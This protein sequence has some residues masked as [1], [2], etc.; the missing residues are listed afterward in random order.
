MPTSPEPGA[1]ARGVRF[2]I[3]AKI[4]LWF[5]FNLAFLGA[6]AWIFARVQLRFGLD[7]LLAGPVSDRLQIMGEV[8]TRQ[9]EARPPAEWPAIL[10]STGR[11]YHVQLALYRNDG[12]ALAGIIPEP[13][14][15]VLQRI[16][17]ARPRDGQHPEPM[18]DGPP[19]EDRKS[20]V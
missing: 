15:E 4:L 20:V 10:D 2:P 14:P 6:A 1:A 7:S 9:L 17:D 19:P 8:L 13:P 3:S 12:K 5:V 18:R 11:S 16:R